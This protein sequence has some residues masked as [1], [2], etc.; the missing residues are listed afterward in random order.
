MR[1]IHS[2]LDPE[3]LL[4][5]HISLDDILGS[6]SSPE[7]R[8]DYSDPK[9]FL[10]VA[11]IRTGEQSHDFAPHLHIKNERTVEW[12]QEIWHVVTGSARVELY[13]TDGKPLDDAVYLSAGDILITYAGGHEY[14]VDPHTVVAEIKSGPYHGREADKVFIEC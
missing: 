2:K 5:R 6:E 12:T 1:T 8:T 3:R 9:E 4:F 14:Q 7:R 13:D 10:Q 11:V